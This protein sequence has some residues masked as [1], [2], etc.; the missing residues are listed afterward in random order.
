MSIGLTMFTIPVFVKVP[1][2]L[3]ALF[4]YATFPIISDMSVCLASLALS[5]WEKL[6]VVFTNI[7]STKFIVGALCPLKV[8]TRQAAT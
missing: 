3:F 8:I 6:L 5:I 1:I 4:S 7:G 2:C